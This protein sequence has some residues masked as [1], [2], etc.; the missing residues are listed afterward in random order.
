MGKPKQTNQKKPK[1][2]SKELDFTKIK[3]AQDK[4]SRALENR[5]RPIQK[6]SDAAAARLLEIQAAFTPRTT[7]SRRSAQG[8][9]R[10]GR[11]ICASSSLC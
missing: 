4:L 6:E 3:S 2:I 11:S 7:L 8:A 9:R 5:K 1:K 10:T